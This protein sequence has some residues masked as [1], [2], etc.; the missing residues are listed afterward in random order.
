MQQ[1]Q[2]NRASHATPVTCTGKH[3]LLPHA[4]PAW[5]S[6]QRQRCKTHF[7][8]A[9]TSESL[10]RLYPSTLTSCVTSY[11][12]FINP[13]QGVSRH[14]RPPPR[15]AVA[16]AAADPAHALPTCPHVHRTCACSQPIVS[17]VAHAQ[18]CRLG[19]RGHN[20]IHAGSAALCHRAA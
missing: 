9:S 4:P 11:L 12:R 17:V 3:L 18:A 2:H 5:P 19:P 13:P 7:F 10:S 15:V 16:V 8:P 14:I 20:G 6:P 1:A